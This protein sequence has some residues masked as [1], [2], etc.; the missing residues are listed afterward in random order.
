ME[1]NIFDTLNKISEE[2]SLNEGKRIRYE[3]VDSFEDTE[4]FDT[5][6]SA[7]SYVKKGLRS[8]KFIQEYYGQ[9]LTLYRV[10]DY[11]DDVDTVEGW[12]VFLEEAEEYIPADL[13]EYFSID[14]VDNLPEMEDS[15][16]GFY[17]IAQLS[18]RFDDDEDVFEETLL[19]LDESKR[20]SIVVYIDKNRKFQKITKDS[21]ISFVNS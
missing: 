14:W 3:L 15:I 5:K 4:F 17:A 10:D 21:L 7:L 19:L 11:T 16:E 13:Q 9:H 2:E 8:P 18:P 6:A 20:K 1:H 12:D